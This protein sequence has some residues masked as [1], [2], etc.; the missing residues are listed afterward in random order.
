MSTGT[1]TRIVKIGNSQGIR[2]PKLLLDQLGL[3]GEVELEVEEGRLVVRPVRGSRQGWEEQ[4]AEMA[5]AGDDRLLDSDAASLTGWD[6][7]E[8][9]W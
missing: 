2:I 6:W 5:Q 4:F 1:R 3:F 7:D 8:W 9:E